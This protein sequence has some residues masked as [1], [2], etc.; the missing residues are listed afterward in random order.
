MVV[1]TSCPLIPGVPVAVVPGLSRCAERGV[2]VKGGGALEVMAR[3]RTPFFDETGALTAGR[4]RLTAAETGPGASED[5]VPR[6][7]A[8]LD[9]TSRH[10]IRRGRGRRRPRP[11]P[12]ARPAGG[13]GGEPGA[14][15]TVMVD[16]RRVSVGGRA[17][18]AARAAPA[19]WD[20][21][22]LRR[23]RHEDATA[24]FVAADGAMLGAI[25][26]DGGV[27]PDAPRALRLPRRAGVARVVMLTGDRRD[28]AEAIGAAIGV[29][30]VRAGLR[31]QDQLAAI[32]EARRA[33]EV[34]A[35]VGDGVNDAPTL[36]AAD[37]GVAMGARGPGASPEAAD[38]VLLAVERGA[39]ERGLSR[40]DA[41]RA[42]GAA[43][44]AAVAGAMVLA[45]LPCETGA[46][47]RG[48]GPKRNGPRD[49]ARRGLDAVPPA[50]R[51][52]AAGSDRRRGRREATDHGWRCP[53]GV[54]V[55]AVLIAAGAIAA[56]LVARDAPNFGV[57]QGMVAVAL[58][59]AIVAVLAFFRRR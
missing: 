40:F 31:P 52:G 41:P 13:G 21:R 7:A 20:A 17:Y 28:A 58:I 16:G 29:D 53:M 6:P 3:V 44:T 43:G 32:A 45:L 22:P 46:G 51:P 1:A 30:G 19:A 24:A 18:V 56:L 50:R 33:G 26:L 38:V 4:A 5:E 14:G 34:C 2:P 47:P 55:R 25:P 48:A 12:P 35:I 15:V 42:G 37:V 54:L 36:A 23:M 11:R 49:G 27:R 59:A 39:V 8:G 57:V 10:A 9:R